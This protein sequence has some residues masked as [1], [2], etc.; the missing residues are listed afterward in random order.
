MA[1]VNPYEE[2]SEGLV[3]PYDDTPPPA[4]SSS[5]SRPSHHLRF[6]HTSR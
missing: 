6:P 3:N 1:L 2:K 4:S 5:S